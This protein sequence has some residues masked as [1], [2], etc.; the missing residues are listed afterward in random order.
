MEIR[1]Q[2]FLSNIVGK[3]TYD[4]YKAYARLI[5]ALGTCVLVLLFLLSLF[6]HWK[7]VS[8]I[9]ELV[10][11]TSLLFLVYVASLVLVLD[12]EVEIDEDIKKSKSPS[13]IMTAVWSIVLVALCV[14]AIYFSNK[15]RKNYTFEC[16]T[17]LV[18]HQSRTYHIIDRYNDCEAA[19]GDDLEKM[20]GYDISKTYMLCRDC[21]IWLE[22][23][24]D[25]T[26]R[27]RKE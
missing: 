16:T 13:Y 11:G 26:M 24:D 8:N 6:F 15:Y 1:K 17:F 27:Y 3:E 7:F 19:K 20:K 9:L 21:E 14:S 22:D 2:S 5:V 12:Y 10:T 25:D 4:E 18:D 23:S